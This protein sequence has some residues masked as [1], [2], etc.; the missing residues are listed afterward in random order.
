[1][2]VKDFVNKTLWLASFAYQP[3][4]TSLEQHLYFYEHFAILYINYTQNYIIK[5]DYMILKLVIA[6]IISFVMKS[7]KLNIFFYSVQR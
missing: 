7:M 3:L 6:Q 4:L 2:I 1:M 5:S